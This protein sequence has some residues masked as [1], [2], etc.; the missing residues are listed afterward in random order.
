MSTGNSYATDGQCHNAEPGSFNHE[1]RQPATWVG[2][3]T[4]GFRSGFCDACKANGSEARFYVN[5]ARV[6]VHP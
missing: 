2:T 4:N 3:K 1:C 5:W 6:E